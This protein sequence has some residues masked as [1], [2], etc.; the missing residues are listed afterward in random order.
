MISHIL[1]V[2]FFIALAVG[3]ILAIYFGTRAYGSGKKAREPAARK[4]FRVG[5]IIAG[6]ALL[7]L[8]FIPGS[9]HQVETGTVAVVR[10]LGKIEGVRNPGTYFDLYLTR[11]L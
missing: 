3:A 11:D 6:V 5:L 2:L 4:P 10:Q 9:F 1:F 7:G 8:A